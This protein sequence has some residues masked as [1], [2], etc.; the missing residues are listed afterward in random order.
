MKEPRYT[1]Q[2]CAEVEQIPGLV[3]IIINTSNK[4]K[5]VPHLLNPCLMAG[6]WPGMGGPNSTLACPQN[7][8]RC[9]CAALVRAE[10]G[11]L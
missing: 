10:N 1:Q 8:R 3:S 2:M 6:H 11:G 5:E 4:T 9:G 7:V